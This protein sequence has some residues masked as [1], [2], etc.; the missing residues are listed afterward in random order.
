MRPIALKTDANAHRQ[1]ANVCHKG[2]YIEGR[3]TYVLNETVL[4]CNSDEAYAAYSQNARPVTTQNE[5]A[6]G[7]QR[8][9]SVR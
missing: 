5:I 3:Y 1:V 6:E 7:L 2:S 8:D 4:I 9:I